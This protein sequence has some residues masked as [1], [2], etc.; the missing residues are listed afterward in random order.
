[1]LFLKKVLKIFSLRADGRLRMQSQNK[2]KGERLINPLKTVSSLGKT[3]S[4]ESSIN[5]K[6]LPDMQH[7]MKY[8]L[9]YLTVENQDFDEEKSFKELTSYM[10][11]YDRILYSTVSQV[12][13]HLVDEDTIG[14]TSSKPDRFGTLLSN[15]EKLLE[16]V[17]ES[18]KEDKHDKAVEDAR[19]AVWK[20]WDHVNLARRQYEDL[21]QSDSEYDKKFEARI[22]L[23]QTKIMSEMNA[24]LLSMVGIFTALAF[25]LFGGISSIE[26]IL[27]DLDEAHLLKL[28]VVSCCWGIGMVN[29]VFVFLF[30]I[31]KMTK[32][33][34]KSTE[35]PKASFWQRYPVVCWINFALISLL[36]VFMWFYYCINRGAV[37]WIDCILQ[38]NSVRVSFGG[39][40]FLII[41]IVAAF[42]LLVRKTK[43][44]GIEDE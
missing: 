24:Q 3:R 18:A 42:I 13:Y 22:G 5:T 38:Q 16:Y 25:V 7:E 44:E 31:G 33:N 43:P 30:C 14:K 41:L 9:E 40:L 4:E 36:I 21:R 35:S 28:L 39:F 2:S 8:F 23:F 20:I 10:R 37:S 26:S 17:N 15:I 34:F 19:K 27:S 6:H 32:L 11:K 29:V 1:M 12:V